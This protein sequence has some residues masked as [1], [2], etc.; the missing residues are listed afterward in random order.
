MIGITS[1]GA[2]IPT[3]RLSRDL[4]AKAWGKKYLDVTVIKP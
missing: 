2:Y 3:Y 4:I 1:Y